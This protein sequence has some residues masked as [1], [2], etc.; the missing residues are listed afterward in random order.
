MWADDEGRQE[1]GTIEF[2]PMDPRAHAGEIRRVLRDEV[3]GTH[4][5]CFRPDSQVEDQR[6]S[7]PAARQRLRRAGPSAMRARCRPD[8]I[9]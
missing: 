2:Q 3:P 7:F 1:V 9:G 5:D 8:G 6:G 4:G